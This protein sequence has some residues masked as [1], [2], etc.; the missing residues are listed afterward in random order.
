VTGRV[1]GISD[2][3]LAALTADPLPPNLFT[4]SEAALVRFAQVSTRDITVPQ[5]LYDELASHFTTQQLMEVVF[6]VGMS[7]LVNRFHATFL[8]D[9]DDATLEELATHAC[10]VSYP[11]P[12]GVR[13]H[14]GTDEREQLGGGL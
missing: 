3:Q 9:V 8:T 1:A 14:E 7:N 6:L 11:A 2:G 4:E 13:S 10:P 5:D 12:G